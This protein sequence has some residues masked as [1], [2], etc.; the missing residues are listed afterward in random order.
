MSKLTTFDGNQFHGLV[1][2][3]FEMS[4][5]DSIAEEHVFNS[6]FIQ[7]VSKFHTHT[8]P[9]LFV[10]LKYIHSITLIFT[11]NEFFILVPY[12]IRQ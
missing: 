9:I 10:G 1:I 6:G 2:I 11:W 5:P 7:N 8:Y 3:H 4:A 12:R